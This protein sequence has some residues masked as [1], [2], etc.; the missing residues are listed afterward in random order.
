MLSFFEDFI[1]GERAVRNGARV[2]AVVWSL[3]WIVFGFVS[4]I[5]EGLG[6]GGIAAHTF[7]PGFIFLVSTL[8][9]FWRE[10]LGGIIILVEGLI[11]TAYFA[12]RLSSIAAVGSYFVLFYGSI[13]ALLVGSIFIYSWR[14]FK[15]RRTLEKG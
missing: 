15:S 4:G 14:T 8:I 6:P 7:I 1:L 2:I 3:S 5:G 10:G 13:P 11:I 12:T 9:A